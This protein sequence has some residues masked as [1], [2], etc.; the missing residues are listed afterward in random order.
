MRRHPPA[1]P[2]RSQGRVRLARIRVPAARLR[3]TFAQLRAC[4]NGQRECQVLWV[5]P[6]SDPD[7]VS[8][9]VHPIHVARGDG[10]ELDGAWLTQF[11]KD[12]AACDEGV[13]VQVHTHP[14][15]AFHS[16]T[17][18]AWPIIHTPGFL[19]LVIPRFATGPDDFDGCYLTRICEDGSWSEVPIAQSMEVV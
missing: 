2:W 1:P 19:S 5:G 11:W 3:E 17:D 7:Q 4:G 12:L 16:T 13:R 18:D 6:W 9:V 15:E 10:F 14:F 8:R